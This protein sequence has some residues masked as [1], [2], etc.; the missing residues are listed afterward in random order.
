MAR[1]KPQK[2]AT[3]YVQRLFEDEYVQD[4]LREAVSR[5]RSV[6]GRVR[7]QPAQAAE[8]KKLYTNVRQAATSIRKAVTALRRPEPE[9]PK[10]RFRTVAI[11]LTVV[12]ASVLVIKRR[13]QQPQPAG[14]SETAAS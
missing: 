5:L 13:P 6:Y 12:A 3:Y 11:P 8:D 10:H 4:Q 14:T 9:P 1:N 2:S 7:K